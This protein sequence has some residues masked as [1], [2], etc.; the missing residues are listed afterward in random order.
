MGDDGQ[1][2]WPRLLHMYD[3]KVERTTSAVQNQAFSFICCDFKASSDTDTVMAEVLLPPALP[4]LRMLSICFA[5]LRAS[6]SNL[7][8]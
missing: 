6:S 2:V 5:C 4:V 1:K 7:A 3:L 8:N